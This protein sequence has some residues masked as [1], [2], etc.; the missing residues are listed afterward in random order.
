MIYFEILNMLPTPAKCH[1]SIF[2]K[3][4]YKEVSILLNLNLRPTGNVEGDLT[5]YVGEDEIN[6]TT[7][8]NKK[9]RQRP[10]IK[11]KSY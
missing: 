10:D 11:I 2:S 3:E 4:M 7:L 8:T 6:W 9:T 5:K 1:F